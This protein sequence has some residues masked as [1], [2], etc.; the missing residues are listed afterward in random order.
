[1]TRTAEGDAGTAAES[2]SI[3]WRRLS[4]LFACTRVCTSRELVTVD[5]GHLSTFNSRVSEAFGKMTLKDHLD[6]GTTHAIICD[7]AIVLTRAVFAP[8]FFLS[9]ST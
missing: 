9:K 2:W 4:S 1:M 7:D 5:V 8:I 6:Q 3:R